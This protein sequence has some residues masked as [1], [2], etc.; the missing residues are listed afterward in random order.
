M[1]DFAFFRAGR[2]GLDTDNW[3]TGGV[4]IEIDRETGCLNHGRFSMTH[5]GAFAT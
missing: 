3:A 2:A 1:L 4:M 5:G